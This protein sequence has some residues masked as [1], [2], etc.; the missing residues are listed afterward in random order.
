[1]RLLDQRA[2]P[3]AISSFVPRLAHVE[4]PLSALGMSARN[5]GM[6]MD[7]VPEGGDMAMDQNHDDGLR[8]ASV[9][10]FDGMLHA[11]AVSHDPHDL[12]VPASVE[13]LM[14][15]AEAQAPSDGFMDVVM[16]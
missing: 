1:M 15:A 7:N 12:V 4:R 6:T 10:R 9:P 13:E 16:H 2:A 11:R 3:S 5:G 14:A 8:A